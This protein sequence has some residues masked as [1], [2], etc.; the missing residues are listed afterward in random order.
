LG[1]NMLRKMRVLVVVLGILVVVAQNAA[2]DLY[3]LQIGDGAAA[4]AA[5]AAPLTVHKYTDAGVLQTSLP[6]PTTASG[7][8]NVLTVRGNSSTES[9]MH[10]STNGQYLVM[11][12]FSAAPGTATPQSAGV[13]AARV[14]GRVQLSNFTAAGIDT[15]T[16]LTDAYLGDS[17]RS[18]ASVDGSAFW[19]GGTSNPSGSGGVRYATLG[20]TTSTQ[21]SSTTNNMRV[22]NIFNDITNTPQLYIGSMSGTNIG[23]STVGTGLPTTTGETATLLPG[24]SADPSGAAMDYWFKDAFTLYK[25]DD[26]TVAAGGGVQKWTAASIGTTAGDY[27]SN[28]VVDG[29]DEVLWRDQNGQTAAGLTADG[30]GS[31]T[32]DSLDYDYWRSRFGNNALTWTLSYT[33]DA[34]PVGTPAS[35]RGLTGTVSGGSTILYATTFSGQLVTITDT[36][37]GSVATLLASPPTNTAFRGVVFVPTLVVDGAAVPEPASAV[38]LLL[39][40]TL[41]GA[42]RRRA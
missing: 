41:L 16:A 17:F 42:R 18:V 22:V 40:L 14:I 3:V 15:T 37:A 8:N 29:A 6:M 5:T 34:G 31:G 20:A 13:G 33:L 35:A 4:L 11:G 23:V 26:R 28:G 38:L 1:Y 2:A 12:G 30:D 21:V 24:M 27:N 7:G 10:L 32:V 25:A 19:M 9:Y 39:G 36:G